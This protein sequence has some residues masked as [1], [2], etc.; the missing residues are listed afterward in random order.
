MRVLGAAQ[1]SMM[2]Q[3]SLGGAGF[4]GT[5]TMVRGHFLL[6]CTDSCITKFTSYMV[7]V[8][9]SLH[10]LLRIVSPSRRKLHCDCERIRNNYNLVLNDLANRHQL[11]KKLNELDAITKVVTAVEF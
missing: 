8:V 3:W 9:T 6:F 2:L 1:T 10:E 5:D 11:F 4:I 7:V